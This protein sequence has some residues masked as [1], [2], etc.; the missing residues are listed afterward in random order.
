MLFRSEKEDTAADV[1]DTSAGR[2]R[3]RTPVDY[4]ELYDKMKREGEIVS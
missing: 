4:K 3:K 1:A 2:K